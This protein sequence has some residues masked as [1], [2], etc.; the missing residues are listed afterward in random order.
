LTPEQMKTSND[1]LLYSLNN[2]GAVYLNEADDYV[3]AIATLERLRS[4]F[5]GYNN[6]SEV[7]FNLYYAYKKSGNEAKAEEMKNLLLVKDPNS[8]YA[9]ILA[10]G[11]DPATSR[12]KT[13][14]ITKTYENIYN[15]FIEGKFDDAE[16][17]KRRADSI[18]Q[19]NYW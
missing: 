8:R 4:K 5:P 10:T 19:T 7:L 11:K 15:L 12:S 16:A 9:S 17:A 2:L 1:S 13:S 3:S 6:M 14:E 18:Y